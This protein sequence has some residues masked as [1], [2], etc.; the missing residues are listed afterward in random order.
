MS[1]L[2]IDP[3][4]RRPA[5]P[6]GVAS[7]MDIPRIPI[8]WR[9]RRVVYGAVVAVAL[10]VL[11]VALKRLRP[12]APRVEQS[13]VWTD[14]VRRGP[15]VREVLGQGSLVADE[16]SFIAAKTACAVEKVLVRP[17]T[18]VK[19]DTLILELANPDLQ[20]QAMEAGR[21]LTQAQAQLLNLEATLDGQRLA[22][23]EA[24]AT[25]RSDL[26]Y[27]RR[28]ARADEALAEAGFLSYL[29]QGQTSQHVDE[30]A[31]R[32]KFERQR[33]SAQTDGAAA[34]IAAQKAQI[35]RLR[36]TSEFQSKEVE[37]LKVRSGVDGVLQEVPWQPGQSVAAGAMLAKVARPDRLKAAVR[38]PETQAKDVAV[39]QKALIDTRN[40]VVTGT[41]AR[42]DPAAQAG[43]VLVDVNLP[44]ALPA[45]A[46]PDLN[47]EGT[48]EI[49]RLAEVLSVARPA[50][51]QPGSTVGLFRLERDGKT[52]VR[53]AVKLGRS[54]V[55]SI[56]ILAG[57]NEG[58]RV[59]LS[60]M[61]Q[62]DQMDRIR[63]Q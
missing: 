41:V 14:A 12:A 19:A 63:L 9:R 42:I 32:L 8:A 20:L 31:G 56:E 10:V 34:Q 5:S 46:R 35:D 54:S 49:E 60:D 58:D 50:I 2:D 26:A 11:M 4:D 47:I 18:P 28:R 6:G 48:I 33:L 30:V 25:L 61:S 16:V 40:G 62:W 36:S 22:Q 24:V 29:E 37:A 45:G 21:Q 51:G 1:F 23:Q 53:T 57:L 44:P 15:M 27:A 59:I 55:K 39:G 38:I 7:M 13:T 3:G 17:G 52:A 43:T